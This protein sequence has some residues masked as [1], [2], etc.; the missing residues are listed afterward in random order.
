ML[1]YCLTSEESHQGVS[2]SL[3]LL[4][5]GVIAAVSFAAGAADAKGTCSLCSWGLQ[6][7]LQEASKEQVNSTP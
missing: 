3:S 7:V 6:R 2:Y 1:S 4:S 5:D